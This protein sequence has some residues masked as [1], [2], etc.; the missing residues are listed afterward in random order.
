MET[1]V[2]L[3]PLSWIVPRLLVIALSLAWLFV[4]GWK[5]PEI[6][7]PG[8]YCIEVKIGYVLGIV[9]FAAAGLAAG[10]TL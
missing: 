9:G 5:G 2:R 4:M 3:T 1:V 10:L 7:R 8:N 6:M